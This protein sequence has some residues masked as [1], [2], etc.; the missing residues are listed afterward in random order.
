MNEIDME[1]RNRTRHSAT[2]ARLNARV[3]ELEA[4]TASEKAQLR[5]II[6]VLMDDKGNFNDAIDELATM[7][8][9]VYPAAA[10]LRDCKEVSFAEVASR[11]NQPFSVTVP[12][13]QV[14][15]CPE[16]GG[17]GNMNGAGNEDGGDQWACGTCGDKETN[18]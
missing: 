2:I 4:I 1:L 16:C 8:G 9:M 6:A 7:A 3:E 15:K 12:P 18:K 10:I 13:S 17:N 11:P 14:E 5:R